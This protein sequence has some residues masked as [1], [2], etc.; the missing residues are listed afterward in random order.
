M[1]KNPFGLKDGTLVT[2]DQVESGL[3][4]GCVCPSCGGALVAHKG[5][6]NPYQR[7]VKHHFKHHNSDNCAHGLETATHL[8]AKQIIEQEK[9]LLLPNLTA[10]IDEDTLRDLEA[11]R[12]S[13]L[14]TKSELPNRGS[15]PKEL[16][17]KE[18]V[19]AWY[20][21]K[22]DKVELEKKVGNIIPDVIVTA[23]Q[24]RLLVEILVT[25][26][27]DEKKLAYIKEHQLSVVEYDFS[28]MK[29]DF[30]PDHLEK[31]LTRSYK[32]AKK[33]FGYGRW[34]HSPVLELAKNKLIENIKNLYPE[35]EPEKKETALTDL[36]IRIAASNEL[37]RKRAAFFA[38]EIIN[39]TEA[40]FIK[41]KYLNAKGLI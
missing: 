19:P 36:Q 13:L 38:G 7:H 41:K 9:L 1:L 2:I 27:I 3:A 40:A 26:G 22:I 17:E 39:Q 31:V 14:I 20:V 11:K 33:G 35:E 34:V 12:P 4:C 24:N 37:R 15:Y 18:L 25:H 16:I 10:R 5:K 29:D 28:K 21:L 30:D 6:L 23:K 8:F 32:G